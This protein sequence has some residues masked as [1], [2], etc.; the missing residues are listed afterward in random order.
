MWWYVC[1]GSYGVS[2][3]IQCISDG[4]WE[5]EHFSG[6]EED[7]VELHRLRC[8]GGDI[9]YQDSHGVNTWHLRPLDKGG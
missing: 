6:E 4:R 7:V 5:R 3:G 2:G 8:D 1:P 9:I